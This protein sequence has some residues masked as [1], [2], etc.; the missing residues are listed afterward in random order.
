MRREFG[1]KIFSCFGA[2]N[3]MMRSNL[4]LDTACSVAVGFKPFV[5]ASGKGLERPIKRVALIPY[6]FEAKNGCTD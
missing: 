5:G 3:S 6:N 4:G 1:S 2:F